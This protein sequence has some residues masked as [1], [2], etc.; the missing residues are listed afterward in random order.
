M[1]VVVSALPQVIQEKIK[2][3]G[4]NIQEV[5]VHYYY[6]IIEISVFWID[7]LGRSCCKIFSVP[8]P[9]MQ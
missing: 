3:L 4:T 9:E 6:E 1:A 5:L 2:Q 7:T 8:N